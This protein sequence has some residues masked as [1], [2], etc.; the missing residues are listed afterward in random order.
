MISADLLREARLRG[1]ELERALVEACAG[2]EEEATR[3]W[4]WMQSGHRT[5][6]VAVARV[7]SLRQLAAAVEDGGEGGG[8][9]G[10]LH[11][12]DYKSSP[13]LGKWL[14]GGTANAPR[15]AAPVGADTQLRLYAVMLAAATGAAPSSVR[16]RR[17]ETGE[18]RTSRE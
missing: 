9:G 11:V 18:E 12:V 8:Q 16:W 14:A 7:P 2:S 5:D 1:A 15:T 17:P 6:G 10:E 3:L 4:G 13:R